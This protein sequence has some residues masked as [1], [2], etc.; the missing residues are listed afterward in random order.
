MSEAAIDP[1]LVILLLGAI[2]FGLRAGG[3]FVMAAIP[4]TP[5]VRRGLEALPGAIIVS[6]TLPLAWKGGG[7]AVVCLIV[8]AAVMA[9]TRRDWLAVLA[10]MAAAAGLRAAGF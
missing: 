3:Y 6:T 10:G 1:F 2:T 4:V 9:V 5:R 7:P 8:A